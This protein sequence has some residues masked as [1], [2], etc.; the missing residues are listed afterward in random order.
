MNVL[1]SCL[2]VYV[3]LATLAMFVVWMLFVKGPLEFT[4]TLYWVAASAIAT[5]LIL[6]PSFA[7]GSFQPLRKQQAVFVAVGLT[8]L[9]GFTLYVFFGLS[10]L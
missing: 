1:V 8:L 3:P 5:S 10:D 7:R 2:I 4:T 9:A 6:W